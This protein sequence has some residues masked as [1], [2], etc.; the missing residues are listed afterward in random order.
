MQERQWFTAD[1]ADGTSEAAVM[2][3][4]DVVLHPSALVT[5]QGPAGTSTTVDFDDAVV[6]H[7]VLGEAIRILRDRGCRE[8]DEVFAW[9]REHDT[10]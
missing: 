5:I 10:L 6:L 9:L 2:D 4:I 1:R 8:R 7:V 3:D